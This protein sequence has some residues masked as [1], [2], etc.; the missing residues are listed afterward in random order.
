MGNQGSTIS[1]HRNPYYLSIQLGAKLNKTVVQQNGQRITY[2]LTR[3]CMI[4]IFYVFPKV[5]N[6]FLSLQAMKFPTRTGKTLK[7]DKRRVCSMI[8]PS[9]QSGAYLTFFIN[10]Y[11]KKTDFRLLKRINMEPHSQR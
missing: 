10:I 8:T 6:A 11:G 7:N 1:A 2:I 4:F 3:P 9:W 5:K